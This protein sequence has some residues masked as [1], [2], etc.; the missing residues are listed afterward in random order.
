MTLPCV[1]N[2]TQSTD[3]QYFNEMYE[4]P[5]NHYANLDFVENDDVKNPS[6]DGLWKK[7]NPPKPKQSFGNYRAEPLVALKDAN[8][9]LVGLWGE[10]KAWACK[11]LQAAV[12]HELAIS[13]FAQYVKKWEDYTLKKQENPRSKSRTNQA[14]VWLRKR[15]NMV[16]LAVA[17]FPVPL[18]NLKHD[19][20]RKSTAR[21]W[22][23][24]CTAA[25]VDSADNNKTLTEAVHEVELFASEWGFVVNTPDQAFEKFEGETDE[26]FKVRVE[27]EEAGY[28]LTRLVDDKWWYRKIDVAYGRFCEHCQILNGRVRKGVSNYLSEIGIRE[29]RSRRKASDAALKRLVARNEETGEEI[30]LFEVVN[31]SVANRAIRRAELMTRL[32]GCESIAQENGLIGALFTITAPSKYHSYTVKNNQKSSVENEKYE[33][34]TPPETQHYL[35]SVFAK[36]RAKLGRLNVD[37]M[38]FRVCEPHHDG[39]PHWHALFFF[40]SEHEQ[41]IRYVLA[42][43]FTLADRDELN[44]TRQDIANWSNAVLG[45][46]ATG[47]S[48]LLNVTDKVEKEVIAPIAK[49][50][51]V[52]FD[53]IKID[54]SLGSAT[55]YIAKY[56]AKNIDGYKLEDDKEEGTTADKAAFAVCGWASRW[57]IRQFQPIGNPS[58]QVWRELRRLPQTKDEKIIKE[59]KLKARADAK[60]KGEIYIEVRKEK[61]LTELRKKYEDIEIARIG[62]SSGDWG[63]F[64]LSNGGLFCPRDA[65]PIRILYKGEGNAYGEIV[66]K[67]KGITAFNKELETRQDGWVIAKIN[68]SRVLE[69]EK[70]DSFSLGALSITVRGQFNDLDIVSLWSQFA[71]MGERISIA[72]FERFLLNSVIHLESRT[73]EG[74]KRQRKAK[75]KQSY[76]DRGGYF[77]DMWESVSDESFVY[78]EDLINK[79]PSRGS[80]DDIEQL[81]NIKHERKDALKCWY[82][83]SGWRTSHSVSSVDG[84]E[85]ITINTASRLLAVEQW[86]KVNNIELIKSVAEVKGEQRY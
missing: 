8:K 50:V 7:Y 85:K 78:I 74:I 10:D 2:I 43:Y 66:K 68:E 48:V 22:A 19:G 17:S 56:I 52:R 86:C 60:E 71:Q 44:I 67:I 69:V 49:R 11:T 81:E 1:T 24:K 30:N 59:A 34:A 83:D 20:M 36:A 82:R 73:T 35:S 41:V 38:G 64:M 40:K 25:V 37:F 46:S 39:T 55:G 53:Y 58:V 28:R 13:L 76:L 63:L 79:A 61:L 51:K 9:G 84:L 75:L 47:K 33:G 21:M 65:F 29:F 5:T 26:E 12:P 18:D 80:I 62:A 57:G 45:K 4:G 3:N 42:E 15:I 14:N 72:D 32:R 27:K 23:D 70:S 54:P 31:R 16:K 77:V 6:D